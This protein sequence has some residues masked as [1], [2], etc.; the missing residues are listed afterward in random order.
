MTNEKNYNVLTQ[1]Q[2]DTLVSQ[3]CTASDWNAVKVSNRF[4][5]AFV[6]NVSFFGNIQITSTFTTK[7]TIFILSIA[8]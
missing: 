8:C 3:G 4:E 1:Q 5:P 6:K 7:N 2:I